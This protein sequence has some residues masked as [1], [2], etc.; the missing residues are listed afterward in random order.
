MSATARARTVS[1]SPRRTCGR[2]STT[3]TAKTNSVSGVSEAEF[4]T[5]FC[6]SDRHSSWEKSLLDELDQASKSQATGTLQSSETRQPFSLRLLEKRFLTMRAT[7]VATVIKVFS[8]YRFNERST[9]RWTIPTVAS[10]SVR[11]LTSQRME[12]FSVRKE[13]ARTRSAS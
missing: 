5:W 6:A 13:R 4:S 9:T 3:A 2:S 11:S 8:A 12:T 7:E 1:R 10:T